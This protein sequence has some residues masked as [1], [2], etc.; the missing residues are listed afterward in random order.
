M[1]KNERSTGRPPKVKISELDN[2]EIEEKVAES[3][4]T[5]KKI[6][7]ML[8]VTERTLNNYKKDYPE[9]FQSL[10]RGKNIADGKVEIALYQ[11]A[12]GYSYP[13]VHILRD[14]TA[15]PI[16]KHCAP[17]PT[18]MIFWLK[19]RQPERWRDKSEVEFT[20]P[21]EVNIRDYR[22]QKT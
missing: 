15:I 12:V 6:A 20:K 14:G 4:W 13:D 3:G 21:L 10:K 18:S 17:D 7:E 19:N 22:G 1:K 9:F 8:G 16:I 5:D 11:R 2:K